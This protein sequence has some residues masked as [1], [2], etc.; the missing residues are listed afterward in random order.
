MPWR[1][2]VAGASIRGH[3][4]DLCRRRSIRAA[5]ASIRPPLRRSEPPHDDGVDPRPPS[6]LG[7]PPLD[8]LLPRRSRPPPPRSAAATRGAEENT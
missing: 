1:R 5:G 6:R 2:S 3:G 7:A 8:P 4:V